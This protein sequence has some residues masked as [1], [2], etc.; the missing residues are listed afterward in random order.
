VK[1]RFAAL[2][3]VLGF[4]GCGGEDEKVTR[5]TSRA[6]A[7]TPAAATD[8]TCAT[9]GGSRRYPGAKLADTLAVAHEVAPAYTEKFDAHESVVASTFAAQ[10]VADCEEADDPSYRPIPAL[11]D[12][13]DA[14]P[15]DQPL[16]TAL[17]PDG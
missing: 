6:P 4:T 5:T 3:C 10:I 8:A 11:T 14:A 12:R 13:A 15:G 16:A 9:I 17:A 2:V 1:V 7:P